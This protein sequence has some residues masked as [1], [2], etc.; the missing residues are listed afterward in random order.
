MIEANIPN[1]KHDA[2]IYLKARKDALIELNAL[3]DIDEVETIVHV[4]GTMHNEVERINELLGIEPMTA[5]QY[6]KD[7]TADHNTSEQFNEQV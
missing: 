6:A 2:A 4:L 5:E 1:D 3:F 7:A